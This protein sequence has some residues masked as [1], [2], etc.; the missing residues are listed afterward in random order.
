MTAPGMAR[1]R[2]F[3]L[4]VMG[5]VIGI[6]AGGIF[7]EFQWPLMTAP[8]APALV[9]IVVVDRSVWLRLP[10]AAAAVIASVAVALVATDGS[11]GQL[12]DSFTDGPQRLLSTEWP[13]PVRGDLVGT[14][15]ALI[16]TCVVASAELARRKRWH[17]APLT[18]LLL[19]AV[20]VVGLSA[21]LGVRWGLLVAVGATSVVFATL[22]ADDELRR[23]LRLLRGE[24]RLVPLLLVAA[25]TTAVV[26]IPIGLEARADPRRNDTAQQTA[27]VLDP[28]QA[29][30]ALRS[31]DPP[32]VLHEIEMLSAGAAPT[33]WRTAALDTY[34]GVRWT[35][36]LT[37][38]PIGKTLGPSVDPVVSFEV[39]FLDDDTSLVPFP[40]SPVSVDAV[41]E[42]DPERTVVRLFERPTVGDVVG[43]SATTA[44]TADDAAIAGLA[45]RVIDDGVSGLSELAQQLGGDGTILQQL[46]RIE[47]TMRNDWELDSEV[48][49]GGLQQALIERFLRETRR[50]NSEQFASGFALLARSLGADARV[51]TGFRTEAPSSATFGLG[52]GDATVW[53]E[54]R[55]TDG[56]WFPFEPVPLEEVSGGEPP[57]PEPQVQTPAAPQPPIPPPPEPSNDA[58]DTEATEQTATSSALSTAITWVVRGV[59]V[60][61]VALLPI[62]LAVGAILGTKYRRRRR[63]LSAASAGE[64]IRGAWATATDALVDAGLSI[65]D[66]STDAEIAG[67]GEPLVAT[68]R[69]PLHR[70]ASLATT[71]TFGEPAHPELLADDAASCLVSVETTMAENR[72]RWQRVRWRLSLRSLRAATRS[73]VTG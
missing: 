52:S 71:A 56:R 1:A 41:V 4:M 15:T 43:A 26:S 42:T 37:L 44:P 48:Q 9:L 29:T 25:A 12:V 6:G 51:A 50:G 49:G 10:A 11:I 35:P 66:S 54:V 5:V 32:I 36:D 68:A 27:P 39:S 65:A 70:L 30:T 21:P 73:P 17:L 53:P 19:V 63:R 40:G 45:A 33:L 64:R 69:R 28:I 14:V 3:V 8:L 61:G 59:T 62:L 60:V 34:D 47:S 24:R 58:N 22:R 13:S 23:R 55:L 7:D 72:S 20:I 18:P 57:P 31:L 67:A 2:I 38:R 46:G 16:A